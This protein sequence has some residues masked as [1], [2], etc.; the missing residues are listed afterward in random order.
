MMRSSLS[1]AGQEDTL[2]VCTQMRGPAESEAPVQWRLMGDCYNNVLQLDFNFLTCIASSC[3]RMSALPLKHQQ[4]V[5]GREN[6]LLKLVS[7]FISTYLCFLG[8]YHDSCAQWL[9]G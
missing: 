4:P 8:R 5:V 1:H 9:R 3:V 2:H 7:C 6:L